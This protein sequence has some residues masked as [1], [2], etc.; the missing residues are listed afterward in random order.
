MLYIGAAP[1]HVTE[2][3]DA[4]GDKFYCRRAAHGE[5]DQVVQ[6]IRDGCRRSLNP[7]RS[8]SY[9]LTER[10]AKKTLLPRLITMIEKT[11]PAPAR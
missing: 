11:A 2:V 6:H 4:L 3:F 5:V 9:D 1:S 10:Y 8:V 7:R